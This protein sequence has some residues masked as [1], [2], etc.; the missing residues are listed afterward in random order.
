ML[1]I[2]AAEAHKEVQ[3]APTIHSKLVHKP[4]IAK[5]IY[6]GFLS[7]SSLQKANPRMDLTY[8]SQKTLLWQ[9]WSSSYTINHETSTASNGFWFCATAGLSRRPTFWDSARMPKH[10]DKLFTFSTVTSEIYIKKGSLDQ[11][12]VRNKNDNWGIFESHTTSLFLTH[13][14]RC[15]SILETPSQNFKGTISFFYN[16]WAVLMQKH[17]IQVLQKRSVKSSC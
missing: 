13:C 11:S 2:S 6:T 4:A 16:H 17:L 1:R 5:C 14:I 9:G 8:K 3:C 10:P 15:P 12:V 7:P